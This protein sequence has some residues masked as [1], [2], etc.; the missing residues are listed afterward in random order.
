MAAA[1]LTP[2]EGGVKV[3][4]FIVDFSDKTKFLGKPKDSSVALRKAGFLMHS[5]DWLP[6][7]LGFAGVKK[8]NFPASLDGVDMSEAIRR[9]S[10]GNGVSTVGPRSETLLELLTKED[11]VFGEDL[12]AFREGDWKL[13]HGFPRDPGYYSESAEDRL[14]STDTSLTTFMGEKFL[15]FLEQFFSEGAF[16]TTRILL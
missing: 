6:T 2:Y 9:T 15:R 13:V 11:A 1:K 8:S 12:F 3:P 5:S 10:V 7:L 16:D 14:N 4:A